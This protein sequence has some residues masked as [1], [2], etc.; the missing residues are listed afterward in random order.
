M[1]KLLILAAFAAMPLFANEPAATTDSAAA[2]TTNSAP[3]ATTATAT[4]A[5]AAD[6]KVT[7]KQAKAEC[8]KE[9]KKKADLKAC[10][11][12]KTKH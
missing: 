8:Q 5:S 10:I 2:A 9:G 3:A 7:Y 4:T 6:T 1:K 11:K 12:E